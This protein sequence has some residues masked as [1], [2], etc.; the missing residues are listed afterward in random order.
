[1]RVLVHSRRAVDPPRAMAVREPADPDLG[2]AYVPLLARTRPPGQQ[3]IRT[4]G[5]KV[6]YAP[7][8]APPA[9]AAGSDQALTRAG[10][11]RRPAARA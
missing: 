1:M 5:F 6:T 8:T 9:K 7:A 4:G 2:L 3:L 11:R 10:A